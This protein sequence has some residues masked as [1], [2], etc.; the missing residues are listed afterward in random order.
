MNWFAMACCGIYCIAKRIE[1]GDDRGHA[2]Y[3]CHI[4]STYITYI[5]LLSKID[6]SDS[7][8]DSLLL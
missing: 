1:H 7:D 8:D 6:D 3:K 4:I 5:V 2:L